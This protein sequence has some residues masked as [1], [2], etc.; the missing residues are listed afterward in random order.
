MT[1]TVTLVH[2]RPATDPVQLHLAMLGDRLSEAAIREDM[3]QTLI[4]AADLG[5]MVRSLRP[6]QAAAAEQAA[7][8]VAKVLHILE[9]ALAKGQAAAR[10]DQR[11]SAYAVLAAR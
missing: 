9:T 3:M 4:S 11:Q 5:R 6:D 8:L 1:S 7:A 10:H 2:A